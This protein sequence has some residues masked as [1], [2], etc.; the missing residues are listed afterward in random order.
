MAEQQK[1]VDLPKETTETPAPV[2][3]VG[4]TAP[5]EA[6]PVEAAPVAATT[7]EDKVTEEAKPAEAVEETKAEEKKEEVTPIEEG[8]LGHKAQGLSFPK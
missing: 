8:H 5:V 1:I 3:T 4:E 7:T 2:T 6:K